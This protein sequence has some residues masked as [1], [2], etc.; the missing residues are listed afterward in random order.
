MD[1]RPTNPATTPREPDMRP[2][3]LR[4]VALL[5]AALTLAACSSGTD[6]AATADATENGSSAAPSGETEDLAEQRSGEPVQVAYT[7][8]ALFREPLNAAVAGDTPV[9]IELVEQG[10]GCADLP[11]RLQTDIA[12]GSTADLALLCF[13]TVRQFIDAGVA[14]PLDDLITDDPDFDLDQFAPESLE[15]FRRDGQLYGLPNALSVGALYWNADLFEAAG[16]DPDTPPQTWSE[17]TEAASALTDDGVDG[18]SIALYE[19]NMI[20]GALFHSNGAGWMNDAETEVTFDDS[21]G[22]EV[23]SL[24]ADMADAGTLRASSD[25][26]ALREAFARGEIAMWADSTA[27]LRL[28]EEQSDFDLR[29]API[30]HP[31]GAT[32]VGALNGMAFLMFTE[33]ES[34][35]QRAWE[36]MKVLTSPE[37]AA[38]VATATGFLSPN[39]LTYT[40]EDLLADSVAADPNTAAATRLIEGSVPI[41]EFPGSRSTEAGTIF[42]D[43]IVQVLQG[44]Q[45]IDDALAT[46]EEQIGLLVEQ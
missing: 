28:I 3:Q 36:A 8:P 23:V 7:I 43:A 10:E 42:R 30:P 25:P 35:R 46:A 12:S 26:V 33:D 44:G 45:P 22:Q 39:T 27:N 4:I 6:E 2:T 1:R 13:S 15:P 32:T 20:F 24:L 21:P 40:R 18:F 14:Q 9:D 5:L 31:E 34:A 29:V 38:E 16:L 19:G 17:L 37:A 41:Y 11:T